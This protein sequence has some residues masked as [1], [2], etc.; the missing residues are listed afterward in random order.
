MNQ[1]KLQYFTYPSLTTQAGGFLP[2]EKGAFACW[3]FYT[4]AQKVKAN[5]G[6]TIEDQFALYDE[7]EWMNKRYEQQARA[8][9]QLYQLESP[10]EFLRFF[11]YVAK[12][13]ALMGY[14]EPAPEY[15]RPLRR[16][17]ANTTLLK[18]GLN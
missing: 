16:L 18:G 10:D 2:N 1:L 7:N 8:V 12:Q 15:T 13:A 14:P 17:I 11:P 3:Y 4:L 6:D 5:V 9:A